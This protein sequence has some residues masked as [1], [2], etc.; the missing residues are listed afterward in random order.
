MNCRDVR[1]RRVYAEG[2]TDVEPTGS[3]VMRGGRLATTDTRE[4][5]MSRQFTPEFLQA[6]LPDEGENT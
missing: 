1:G 5:R 2:V 4:Q 3:L 6:I